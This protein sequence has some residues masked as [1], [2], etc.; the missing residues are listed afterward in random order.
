M[1]GVAPGWSW[2]EDIV[3][4]EVS[5]GVL[6]ATRSCEVGCCGGIYG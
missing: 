2:E 4:R 1:R 6:E 5:R 3:D